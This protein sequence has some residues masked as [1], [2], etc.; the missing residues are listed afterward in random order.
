MEGT[1]RAISGV[2]LK[3]MA[4][5]RGLQIIDEQDVSLLEPQP[6]SVSNKTCRSAVAPLPPTGRV[7]AR[8]MLFTQCDWIKHQDVR[9]EKHP[10]CPIAAV[11]PHPDG[12]KI[13]T[14]GLGPPPAPS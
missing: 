6:L 8:A 14:G 13:A 12:S 3:A 5:T 1:D 4:Q 11:S 7:S 10:L 2:S 9:T